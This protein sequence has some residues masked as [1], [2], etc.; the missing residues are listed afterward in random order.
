MI[1]MPHSGAHCTPLQLQ[2]R[3]PGF[4]NSTLQHTTAEPES[5]AVNH[6]FY[7]PPSFRFIVRMAKKKHTACAAAVST[8]EIG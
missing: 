4:A 3:P 6:V 5:P 8:H 7:A 2:N 1:E